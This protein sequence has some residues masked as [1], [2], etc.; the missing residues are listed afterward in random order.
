VK[1]VLDAIKNLPKGDVSGLSNGIRKSL[2]DEG[3]AAGYDIKHAFDTVTGAL[4]GNGEGT[5]LPTP[6][7]IP[8]PIPNPIPNPIPSPIPSP[9]N[10]TPDPV[11]NAIIKGVGG[12][13]SD[14]RL[15]RDIMKVGVLSEGINLYKFR[16]VLDIQYYVVVIAQEVES[17]KP[18][19]VTRDMSGYLLV[20]YSKLNLQM[21]PWEQWKH[22]W[23]AVSSLYDQLS[24][25]KDGSN[26]LY[27]RS[28]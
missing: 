18:E 7:P 3:K 10:P 22:S 9:S 25:T 17:V 27:P 20:D 12:L 5:A 2:E 8:I 28:R 24:A 13:L 26:S 16:Y 14:I 15:K 23:G 6:A 11:T 1:D 19:A 21:E 4:N